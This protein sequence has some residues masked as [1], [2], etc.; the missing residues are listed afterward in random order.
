MRKVSTCLWFDSNALEAAEFYVGVFENS[1]ILKV[2][3]YGS[4]GVEIHH[5]PAGSVMTVSFELQGAP[6]TALN[7]GPAFQFS[8]AISLVVHCRS[9]NEIDYYWEK[10]SQGGNVEA[11]QC[12]WL[13]DQ[14]GVSWQIAPAAMLEWISDS[15]QAAPDRV[16]SALLSMKKPDI[17][18]LER[19]YHG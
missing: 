12:G 11:Q 5:R 18:A 14:F 15:N 19:A 13:Q 1:K 8:P 3:Q 17:A 4:A 7:G 16:M 10:L 2:V 9:Q 6:F